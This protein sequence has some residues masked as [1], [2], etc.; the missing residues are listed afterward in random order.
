M[1]DAQIALAPEPSG[2]FVLKIAHEKLPFTIWIPVE[3]DRADTFADALMNTM[4]RKRVVVP[5]A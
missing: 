3:R 2:G 5:N 4:R 1:G